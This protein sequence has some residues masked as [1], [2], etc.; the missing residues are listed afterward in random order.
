MLRSSEEPALSRAQMQ[1]VVRAHQAHQRYRMYRDSLDDSDDD[2][3]PQDDDAWLYEDLYIL[4][5]LYSR[6]KDRQQLM[7]LVFEVCQIITFLFL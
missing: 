3:G 6:L 1:R 2:E 5:K 7:E 4:G